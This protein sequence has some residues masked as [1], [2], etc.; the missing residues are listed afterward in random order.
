MSLP[1]R[2]DF[3]DWLHRRRGVDPASCLDLTPGPCDGCHADDQPILLD[4]CLVCWAE[5]YGRTSAQQ[6]ITDSIRSFTKLF[7]G[8]DP[9]RAHRVALL[10]FSGIDDVLRMVSAEQGL[11]QN[12]TT[13]P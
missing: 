13:A 1:V 2:E 5:D 4:Q 10:L 6:E 11:A 7:L 3:R 8:D 12:G 9:D